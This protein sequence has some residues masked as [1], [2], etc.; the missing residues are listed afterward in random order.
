MNHDI[1]HLKRFG[2]VSIIL[3]RYIK[4]KVCHCNHLK[5][6]FHISNAVQTSSLFI[7][8][9]RPPLPKGVLYPLRTTLYNAAVPWQ[10]AISNLHLIFM[11]LSAA[12]KTYR[13]SYTLFGVLCLLLCFI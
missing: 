12:D 4:H 13:W 3:L 11:H 10:L 6:M 2:H 1:L 9:I 8:W 7:Y 5:C